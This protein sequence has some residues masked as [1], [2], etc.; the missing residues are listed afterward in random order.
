MGAFLVLFV[1]LLLMV[2]KILILLIQMLPD[3]WGLI[4]CKFQSYKKP[5]FPKLP[6]LGSNFKLFGLGLGTGIIACIVFGLAL[7]LMLII[8]GIFLFG[9]LFGRL[10]R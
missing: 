5:R 6:S 8:A 1:R 9:L 2:G 4:K 7:K 10:V 3:E